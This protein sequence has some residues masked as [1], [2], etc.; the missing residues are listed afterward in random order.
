MA[1][2]LVAARKLAPTELTGKG[3][4]PGV[5]ADVSS[6]VVAAA[7]AAHAD[8]TLEGLVTRVDSDVPGQLIRA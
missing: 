2:A 6:E 5:R 4:L 7:E 8:P 1:L 3:L